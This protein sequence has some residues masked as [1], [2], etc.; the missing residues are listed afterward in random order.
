MTQVNALPA[1]AFGLAALVAGGLGLA[2][3]AGAAPL[4]VAPLAG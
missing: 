1:R 4:A 3:P 2:G